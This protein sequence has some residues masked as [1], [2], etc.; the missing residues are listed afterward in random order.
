MGVPKVLHVVVPKDQRPVHLGQEQCAWL[1]EHGHVNY[2][3]V[4]DTQHVYDSPDLTAAELDELVMTI[5]EIRACDFCQRI[6]APYGMK[7]RPFRLMLGPTPAEFRRDVAICERCEPL[8]RRNDRRALIE[9]GVEGA[10]EKAVG[11]GGYMAAVIKTNSNYRIRQQILPV[12]K[13]AT[14]AMMRNRVGA[15][16]RA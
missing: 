3:G 13:E 5:P 15:P 1:S 2:R 6:G 14:E 8:V 12:V 4:T 10:K 11:M 7:V 16:F 9:I